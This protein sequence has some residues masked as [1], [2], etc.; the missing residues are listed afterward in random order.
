MRDMDN[1]AAGVTL[2]PPSNFFRSLITSEGGG[3]ITYTVVLNSAPTADVTIDLSS[4]DTTEG[5]VSPASLTFTTVNWN[6][7]Q[8]VTIT[9]VDDVAAD[10]AVNYRINSTATST[11]PDYDGITIGT[12]YMQNTDDES[13]GFFVNPDTFWLFE[14]LSTTV[15]LTKAP[16]ADVTVTCYSTKA[17]EGLPSP[18]TLVFTPVNW[19][20]PQTVMVT[21]VDDGDVDGDQQYEI[22]FNAATSTD[23]DYNGRTPART[24]CSNL[25]DD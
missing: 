3:Q 4:N 15:V 5:T 22:R 21:G 2:D 18:T 16:S 1:E 23:P 10:G 24:Y 25:D 7:E 17:D 19:D 8:T 11:D 13:A 14:T 20:A 9:G 12:V 6:I